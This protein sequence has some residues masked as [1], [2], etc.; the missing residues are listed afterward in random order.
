M[1]AVEFILSSLAVWRI[2][3][4]FF[5]E[6]GP[7]GI[8]ARI[9]AWAATKDKPQ[10][11]LSEL[12]DCFLCLSVWFAGI[13]SLFFANSLGQFILYTLALSASAIFINRVFNLLE[14]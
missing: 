14:R 5:M 1:N 9:R 4:M 11:G 6:F 3:H 13:A 12:F 8:F 7:L 2:T 10:G